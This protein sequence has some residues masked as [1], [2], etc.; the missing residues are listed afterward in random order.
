MG[1]WNPMV[2]LSF[3]DRFPTQSFPSFSIIL[4]TAETHTSHFG[5][6]ALATT[7]I[8]SF[9]LAVNYPSLHRPNGIVNVEESLQMDRCLK[10]PTQRR[11]QPPNLWRHQYQQQDRHLDQLKHP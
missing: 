6:I 2:D 1:K 3:F 9:K 8:G 10:D 11:R 4:G 5:T 7:K